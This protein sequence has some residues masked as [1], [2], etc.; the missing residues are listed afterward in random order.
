MPFL[1]QRLEIKGSIE[2]V[3]IGLSYQTFEKSLKRQ[4]II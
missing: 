3:E 2:C 1:C 4:G